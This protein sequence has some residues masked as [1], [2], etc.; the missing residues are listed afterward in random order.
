MKLLCWMLG[1]KNTI[2]V[3]VRSQYVCDRCERCKQN[4]PKGYP[5]Q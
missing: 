5:W 3:V 2:S 1:H 4:L